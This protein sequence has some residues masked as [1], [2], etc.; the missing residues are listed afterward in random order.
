MNIHIHKR[1][2]QAVYPKFMKINDVNVC[3]WVCVYGGKGASP[4]S[5]YF[6]QSTRQVYCMNKCPLMISLEVFKT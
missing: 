6:A 2:E 3:V 1:K 4:L 5:I